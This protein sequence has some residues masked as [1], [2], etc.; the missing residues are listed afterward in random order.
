MNQNDTA[1]VG[2]LRLSRIECE[3][4]DGVTPYCPSCLGRGV[5]SGR[6]ARRVT[7]VRRRS[8]QAD[9]EAA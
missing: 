4:C 8:R 5:L 6:Q 3:D 1:P 7:T 2:A 9:R